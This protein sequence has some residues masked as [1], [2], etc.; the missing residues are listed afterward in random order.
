[1]VRLGLLQVASSINIRLLL[2][3]VNIIRTTRLFLY[4]IVWI[5]IYCILWNFACS[6]YMAFNCT[7]KLIAFRPHYLICLV[8]L[9]RS[10]GIR[11][12]WVLREVLIVLGRRKPRKV[13]HLVLNFWNYYLL[14]IVVPVNFFIRRVYTVLPI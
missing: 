5:A 14:L 10:I 12:F 6:L 11:C 2:P 9:A 3:P 1:M 7:T 13:C 8:L 4:K